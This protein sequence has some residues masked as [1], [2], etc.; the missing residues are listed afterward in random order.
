MTNKYDIVKKNIRDKIITG[1]FQQSQK[2]PTESEMMASF[3][4][5]RYTVRRA[6]SDLENEN[7]VY[8]VQGGGSFVADWQ[9]QKKS[10]NDPK[11][12][13]ILSTHVASYIFP[14]IIDGADQVISENGYSLILANTHNDPERERV[15]LTSLMSQNLAGLIVEPTQ[16]ALA[17]P[18]ID[19]YQKI[20]QMNIPVIFINATYKNMTNYSVISDDEAAFYRATNYLMTKGHT[21][22]VG[23]FQVDDRQ[24]VHRLN[25]YLKSYQDH[26]AFLTHCVPI[27]YKSDEISIALNKVTDL[28][29][30]DANQRPTAIIA[31]ND[32]LAIRIIDLIHDLGLRVPDDVSVIG[33]DDFQLSKYISPRLTTMTHAKER[34]G[35]DAATLLIQK[36]KHHKIS[37]IVYQSELIERDSVKD[38]RPS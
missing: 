33:F 2:L 36:I 29:I 7:Y 30:D 20:N 3:A 19:L 13:G 28:L 15:A 34:M 18:N 25:G 4:V 23:V 11:V 38:I 17:T 16:S 14:A 22:I 6:I 5:S 10:D 24:G 1:E 21:N 27:M 8:R 31:Y 37:S 26:P 9:T 32:Q 12:I 35:H